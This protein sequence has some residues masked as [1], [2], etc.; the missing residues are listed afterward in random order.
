MKLNKDAFEQA[1]TLIRAGKVH[2]DSDW[3]KV[4]PADQAQDHFLE[5]KDWETYSKWFLGIEEDEGEHTR[6]RYLFLYGDFE[7]VHRS[8]LIAGKKRA[9]DEE[10]GEI[11][12]AIDRLI[13]QIDKEADVITEAS[14]GSFPASDPPNWRGRR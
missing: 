3:E 10:F 7:H 6:G 1:Q 2:Q 5:Q 14:E 8:A 13:R 12:E 11:E 4:R 9:H